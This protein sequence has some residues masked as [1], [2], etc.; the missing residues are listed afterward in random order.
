MLADFLKFRIEDEAHMPEVQLQLAVY[1][2]RI[3][4]YYH[5]SPASYV[6]MLSIVSFIHVLYINI[7]T[8]T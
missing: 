3:V 4:H 5:H 8:Y 2:Q 1:S 6:I 7:V